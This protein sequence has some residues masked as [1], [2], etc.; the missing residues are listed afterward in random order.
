MAEK[1]L[2]IPQKK[3][4]LKLARKAIASELEGKALELPKVSDP[5]LLEH[6][7]AFVTLHENGALRGCIGTFESN[8]ALY[9]VVADMAISA[10][11]QD[12][13]FPPLSPSEFPLIDIEISA[14]TPL[15]PIKDIDEIKVGEHGI[16]IIKGPMRGVLLPQVAT[17]YGWDRYTFLD[18]TCMK[19]GLYPGCW[20]EPDTQILIFSAEVFNEKELGLV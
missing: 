17:E 2:G 20:K 1:R 9:I 4:L 13:R 18:Q 15:R 10:A 12:P 16:Y 7:G 11:F 5:L 6:R 14:L 8:R 3:F 19:A